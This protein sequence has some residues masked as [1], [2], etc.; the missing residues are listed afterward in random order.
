[1]K[2]DRLPEKLPVSRREAVR[3]IVRLSKKISELKKEIKSAEKM[4]SKLKKCAGEG[5]RM[6]DMRRKTLLQSVKITCR[7]I[8]ERGAQE[9]LEIYGNLR[10]YQKVFRLLV[11]QSGTI[12]EIA[13][14]LVEIRFP[15]LQQD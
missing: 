5:M 12:E 4:T 6:L 1:M 11:R 9:F 13:R 8:F 10:D 2:G 3:Q 7:N 15:V 14:K